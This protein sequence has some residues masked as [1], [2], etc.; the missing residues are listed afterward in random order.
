MLAKI[1]IQFIITNVMLTKFIII[2]NTKRKSVKPEEC[3][4][5]KEKEEIKNEN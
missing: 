2:N 5:S 4:R 3:K 1:M